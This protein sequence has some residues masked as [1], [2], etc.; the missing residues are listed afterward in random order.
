MSVID[1]NLPPVLLRSI[2][3]FA[4]REEIDINTFILW[5]LSEKIGEIK[6]QIIDKALR[7]E[8]ELVQVYPILQEVVA[9]DNFTLHIK[10]D[11]GLEGTL[12]VKPLIQREGVFSGLDDPK[13]FKNVKISDDGDHIYWSEEITIGADT[14]FNK[15]LFGD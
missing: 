7:Q 12:D 14:I 8:L 6:G 13:R 11:S 1:V 15:I 3:I 5:A 2:R 10:F 4:E 9:Q